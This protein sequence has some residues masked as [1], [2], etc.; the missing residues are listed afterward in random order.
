VSTAGSLADKSLQ[1][2]EW[3]TPPLWGLRDSAP[4]LHDGRART[5]VE[6]INAHGGQAEASV[7]RF[8][9]LEYLSRSHLLDFLNSLGNPPEKRANLAGL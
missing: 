5:L 8:K 7:N 4:Y 9:S 6:A 1:P 3:K 2:E